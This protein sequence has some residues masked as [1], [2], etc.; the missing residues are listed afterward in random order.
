LPL[1]INARFDDQ[2]DDSRELTSEEVREELRRRVLP[3][4]IFLDDRE[5]DIPPA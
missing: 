4:H 3:D 5:L 2:V 1:Q